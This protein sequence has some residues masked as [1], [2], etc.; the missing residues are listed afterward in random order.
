MQLWSYDQDSTDLIHS[1]WAEM[2][3]NWAIP[4]ATHC[5][6]MTIENNMGDTVIC[7]RWQVTI[8]SPGAVGVVEIVMFGSHELLTSITHIHGIH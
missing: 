7:V 2:S 3:G 1:N 4:F 6:L 5:L 8:A